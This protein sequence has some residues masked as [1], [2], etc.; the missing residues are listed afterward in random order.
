VLRLKLVNQDFEMVRTYLEIHGLDQGFLSSIHEADEMY[1]YLLTG[2]ANAPDRGM[3]S[4]FDTGRDLWRGFRDTL[5]QVGREP[6]EL[7]RVLECACGYGRLTRH[8][9]R[10]LEAAE[11]TAVDIQPRAVEFQRQMFGTQAILSDTD[12]RKVPLTG[13]FDLIIVVSLFSHLPAHRF[14]QWLTRLHELLSPDGLLL[15]SVHAEHIIDPQRRHPSGFTFEAERAE[16]NQIA[17]EDPEVDRQE[18]GSTWA[19]IQAV[20]EI[21][22]RCGVDHLY[23]LPMGLV[24]TQDLYL[25]TR[26]EMPAMESWVRTRMI[27]GFIDYA[28]QTPDGQLCI[29]GWCVD[30]VHGE[31]PT[32]LHVW[33]DGERFEGVERLCE[34]RPDVARVASR[35]D[36]LHTGWSITG[37]MPAPRDGEHLLIA[38]VD[39]IPFDYSWRHVSGA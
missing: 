24:G 37:R 17:S 23:C 35:P 28:R 14:D 7:G 25:A 21:A 32:R 4:Y 33:V 26:R 16:Q 19:T 13:P 20:Q 8:M 18:Y 12:P 27:D 2:M 9:V 11:I 34:A 22:A 39:G 15:F 38:E 29:G 6:K 1:R 3:V 36:W 31:P 10:D 30:T 5:R